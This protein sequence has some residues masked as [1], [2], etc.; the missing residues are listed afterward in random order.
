MLTFC[1]TTLIRSWGASGE[2]TKQTSI[3]LKKARP[4]HVSVAIIKNKQALVLMW[5]I[6]RLLF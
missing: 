1:T 5:E 3:K 2:K 4:Q 6:Y